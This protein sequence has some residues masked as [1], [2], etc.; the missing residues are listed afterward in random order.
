MNRADEAL[1]SSHIHAA[2]TRIRP[3]PCP[4]SVNQDSS[5]AIRYGT[6]HSA[7]VLSL[8]LLGA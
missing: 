5:V 2:A 3:M 8:S 1:L 4:K 6:L 7:R